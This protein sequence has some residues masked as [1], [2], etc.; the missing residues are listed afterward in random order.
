MMGLGNVGGLG[1]LG[2]AAANSVGWWLS[3]AQ[4][5]LDFANDRSFN[6]KTGY[7]AS[8][9]GLLTYTSPSPKMVY[10]TDGVLRYARHN[11]LTY[12]EDFSNAAWTK[13]NV[14]LS[15]GSPLGGVG[16]ATLV[17]PTAVSGEHYLNNAVTCVSGRFYTFSRYVKA[18]GY[19]Y[20][21]MTIGAS[22]AWATFD[23]TDGT[24][25]A[26]SSNG[27]DFS[28]Q[29]A[30]IQD[31]GNG[32]YK[33]SVTALCLIGTSY[34]VLSVVSN[35]DMTATYTKTFT[36]D[37]VSGV[38]FAG[39]QV[40]TGVSIFD[41]LATTS[42]AKYD[43]P[44]DHDPLTGEA[45]G[46]LIEEQRTALA[47]YSQ[48]A[49]QWTNQ[50][51]TAVTSNVAVAPDGTTTA[52]LLARTSTSAAYRGAAGVVKAA[53]AIQYTYSVFAKKSIH[54]YLSITCQG[55]SGSQRASAS[56]NLETGAVGLTATSG[57]YV[58]NS[59]DVVDVGDGWY[60]CCLTFTTDTSAVVT[61]YLVARQN[62][63]A[64]VDGVDTSSDAAAY[65]WGA[66]LEAG[67]FATS[68]IQTG[69]AQVTRAADQVS[70]A[71]SAFNFVDATGTCVV[72]L[73]TNFD[74]AAY[75]RDIVRFTDGSNDYVRPYAYPSRAGLGIVDSSVAQCDISVGSGRAT[76]VPFSLACAWADNDMA[77]VVNGGTVGVDTSGTMP[78]GMT[79]VR[80]GFSA[81]NTNVLSGHIKRFT[82]WNTRKPNAELQVLSA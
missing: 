63:T 80:I 21:S 45:L 16:S 24:V 82:Y 67:A 10:G 14:T 3:G 77:A 75:A 76:G 25:S 15:A 12:S 30:T 1:R 41:Y 42:A 5:D 78:T 17:V 70:L 2:Y 26:T 44:I 58:V 9:N 20:V 47:I 52:D 13:Q 39:S 11:L 23:L 28:S 35:T 19:N 22:R 48:D 60:R 61:P 27:T 6:R 36:G 54:D 81:A 46:V 72:E 33:I 37:G 32:W 18:A 68:Y 74:V 79:T 43:L 65:V 73:D 29:S 62:N 8:P 49:T 56:F 69:S 7:Q 64:V 66:Q 50:S 55:S 31:V 57:S 59:T 71:T 4:L 51:N 34:S 53:S 40:Q 38:L